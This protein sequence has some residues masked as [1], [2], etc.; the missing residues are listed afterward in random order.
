MAPAAFR[1]SPS[2]QRIDRARYAGWR[3]I[4]RHRRASVWHAAHRKRQNSRGTRENSAQA[5]GHQRA[6]QK[7]REREKVQSS[8]EVSGRACHGHRSQTETCGR[9]NSSE[10][11]R[12]NWREGRSQGRGQKRTRATRRGQLPGKE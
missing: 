8:R 4:R 6:A 5:F 10:K 7:E 1:T 3:E 9:R 11:G 12:E 2:G